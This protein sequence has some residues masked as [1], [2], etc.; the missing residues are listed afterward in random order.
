MAASSTRLA[1]HQGRRGGS[2]SSKADASPPEGGGSGG[3]EV[4]LAEM[5]DMAISGSSR[6][7][8]LAEALAVRGHDLPLGHRQAQQ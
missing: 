1:I 7:P 5:D 6:K 8:I 2:E 3:G 4:P